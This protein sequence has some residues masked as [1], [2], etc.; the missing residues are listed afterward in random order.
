MKFGIF[1]GVFLLLPLAASAEDIG[2]SYTS[3]DGTVYTS[4][5]A[6][7][8]CKRYY[9]KSSSATVQGGGDMPYACIDPQFTTSKAAARKIRETES[10]NDETTAK[11]ER[12]WWQWGRDESESKITERDE[13]I[14]KVGRPKASVPP[15]PRPRSSREE[16]VVELTPV[17]E[18]EED[19][20]IDE[21]KDGRIGAKLP[22]APGSGRSTVKILP[23]ASDFENEDGN[24]KG[25]KGG[26]PVAKL[27][28]APPSE[29]FG[30]DDSFDGN[31]KNGGKGDKGGRIGAK[32]P[33]APGSGRST[34]KI[35]PP[36]S[37]FENEDGNGKGKK[38]GR[39][40]AKLPPAPPSEDFGDDDSFDGNGKNGG[41]GD[42]GGRIGAKLPPAPGSGRSTV[43]ILP[44]ASDFEDD[45][46]GSGKGKK[47][48]R[49]VAKLP[50]A[51]PS[52]DFEEQD[53]FGKGK[54]ALRPKAKLPPPARISDRDRDVDIE[55]LRA[56]LQPLTITQPNGKKI[57][58]QDTKP[59]FA[60][61]EV[62]CIDSS[63]RPK[64]VIPTAPW[65]KD[66]NR[67]V[68]QE[69][70]SDEADL[71][72]R[73][74]KRT[75]EQERC[76]A[77]APES[78]TRILLAFDAFGD[79][80]YVDYYKQ[81]KAKL[82]EQD[83]EAYRLSVGKA[84]PKEY[85]ES[86]NI[87]WKY[88]G[89]ETSNKDALTPAAR[90]AFELATKPYKN[91]KGEIVYNTIALGGHSF[92]SA[93]AYKVANVLKKLGVRVDLMV[94]T[95]PR[96]LPTNG[97]KADTLQVP[98]TVGRWV[99]FY[100]RNDSL[101]KGF[102]VDG[103]INRDISDTGVTHAQIPQN[104]EVSKRIGMEIMQLPR[105]KADFKNALSQQNASC[106]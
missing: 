49:P 103:A 16:N 28:P 23:P 84:V 75:P 27:P 95:D 91:K 2:F 99:N 100:Q 48:G 52:E 53:D 3:A 17:I 97:K 74:A 47:G 36:A 42:K 58:I 67:R 13:E 69:N 59:V 98:P 64:D 56:R 77:E 8:Y 81:K 68:A 39:P 70:S 46:D 80:D 5:T 86:T 102:N 40:V 57:T 96:Q 11:G 12:K 24:G 101:I 33:P 7:A 66:V 82:S 63:S 73:M 79:F 50:P 44:P 20:F 10:K 31:G 29:D 21:K 54:K 72:A 37:D 83:A 92:G 93:A 9:A 14:K 43:K 105:C 38:G 25:K 71:Y 85:R 1:F 22:P 26:R 65:F 88:Y 45:F 51:P 90:C 41:K 62:E 87:H 76:L 30:D 89:K 60:G 35:L 61:P 18:G 32:L 94:T 104:V 4:T 6:P 78:P 19:G 34:V 55:G 106:D 15:A